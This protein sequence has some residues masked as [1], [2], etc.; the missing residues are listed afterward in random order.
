MSVWTWLWIF[1]IGAFVVIEGVALARKEPGDTL[2]EHV[3]KWFHTQ[4]GQKW[5]KT[6]RLRR[7]I[8]LA[9]MAWL[10]VHFLTGGLF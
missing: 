10:S 2:S 4:Q 6:T 9:F 5:S 7:F 3:W 1:W 8:L